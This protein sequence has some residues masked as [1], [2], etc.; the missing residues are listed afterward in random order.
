MTRHTSLD[1][2]VCVTERGICCWRRMCS[3]HLGNN[4][5]PTSKSLS[6]LCFVVSHGFYG[7]RRTHYDNNPR[8][9]LHIELACNV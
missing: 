7:F 3:M 8:Y 5:Y 4:R 1:L 6:E 9:K 2:K